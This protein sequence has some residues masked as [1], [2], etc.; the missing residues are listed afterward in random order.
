MSIYSLDDTNREYSVKIGEMASEINLKL[1][2]GRELTNEN[3]L[4]KVVVI[5]FTAA[6]CNVCVKKNAIF[7]ERSL[8][9]FQKRRF[10]FNWC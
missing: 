1:L 8:A 6:W 2:D 7:G 9:K 4:G 3:L 5:K 10:Y